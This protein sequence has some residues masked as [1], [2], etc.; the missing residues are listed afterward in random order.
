MGTE[1]SGKVR[2]TVGDRTPDGL[3]YV[4]SATEWWSRG[5]SDFALPA[6]WQAVV[7]PTGAQGDVAKHQDEMHNQ[8]L[9][10]RVTW[11]GI[12]GET[13]YARRKK[14]VLPSVYYSTNGADAHGIDERAY[15]LLR[16]GGEPT[17]ESELN[18]KVSLD[19]Y[20]YEGLFSPE[21]TGF[22]P[23]APYAD[24]LSIN[25]EV[26]WRQTFA[27]VQSLRVGLE[28]QEN[29]RQDFGADLPALG[30]PFYEIE[31]SSSYVS[32]FAQLD[33]EFTPTLRS[34][35]GA[36]YDYYDAETNRLTPRVGLIWDAHRST[37]LK[38]LYGEAF[39]APN[40]AER[41]P[42]PG[43]VQNPD[44]G[45]E[46]NRSWEFIAEQR[47]GPVW[48]LESH[49]YYTVSEDLIAT[50]PTGNP[51]EFIYDNVSS[52]VTKGF[53]VGPA[54]YFE[55]GVQMRASVTIQ[56]TYDDS[57]DEIVTDAPK[58]L[59]KLQVS[60]PVIEKW[61]RASAEV[62]Y[63]GDRKDG[64][65]YQDG[66]VRDTGDYWNAN[67]TLRAS[68]IWERWDLS[69]SIYNL[70]DN[71]WSDPKNEGQIYSPPRSVMLRAEMDF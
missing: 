69:L 67:F 9:F 24:S 58:T 15:L 60:A 38:L 32:P 46:T 2:V 1:P 10:S 3:D 65:G 45:P 47:F 51:G 55:S 4:V 31:E 49:F 57:T 27:D 16:A 29:L 18:A 6:D 53:D 63:V 70:A 5:E 68:R 36:R 43:I 41:S 20:Q 48:R 71:P 28:Y 13:A 40:V 56:R 50:V 35:L 11:R 52:Y 37:T 12:S 22:E 39:R 14:E 64:G 8:S 59:G 66:I 23:I 21:V 42:A 7:D 44:I 26:S 17:P 30:V 33:W 62:F 19:L 61:L 54:A 34:S 25:S